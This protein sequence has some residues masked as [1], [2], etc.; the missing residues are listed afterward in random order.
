MIILIG[1]V[2]LW[3]DRSF[4][5]VVSCHILINSCSTL[6]S[7]AKKIMNKQMTSRP[8]CK[9]L[10]RIVSFVLASLLLTICLMS[11]VKAQGSTDGTTPLGLSP[12]SPIGSYALS[13][14]EVVNLYN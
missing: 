9:F 13:D 7:R 10:P 4:A 5:A 2:A 11:D 1:R 6:S 3:W 12:G 14:F 8:A